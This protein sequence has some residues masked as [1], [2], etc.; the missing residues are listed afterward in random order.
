MRRWWPWLTGAVIVVV[1]ATRVPLAALRA[2]LNHGPHLALAATCLGIGVATL[3]SDTW[4]TWIGLVSLGISRPIGKILV[5][6]GSTYL[7]FL[8][9]YAVGQGGFGYYLYRSGLTPLRATGTTLFLMGT[10]LATLLVAT[11]VSWFFQGHHEASTANAAMWWVLVAGCAGY[12]LYL[13]IIACSPGFLVRRELLAPLF[14]AGLR[15]HALAMLGRLPHIAVMVLAFWVGMRVWGIEVPFATGIT[16]LPAVVIASVIPISPAGLGTTQAAMVFFFRDYAAG[17]T[18][19]DRSAAVLAFSIVY[20][21]YAVVASALVGLVCTPFA[22]RAG[23]TPA[24]AQ[25]ASSVAA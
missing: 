2:S 11:T 5:A 16:V 18:A 17:A 24:P 25:P 1:I 7:L 9:N 6:R 8:I 14:D 22:R 23:V 10:N 19:D 12:A 3:L 4:A 20:L 21:A 15:G 13:L